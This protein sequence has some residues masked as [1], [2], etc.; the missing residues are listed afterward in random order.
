[1]RLEVRQ[2]QDLGERVRLVQRTRYLHSDDVVRLELP[3]PGLAQVDVLHLTCAVR[4]ASE[5]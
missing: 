5:S 2:A 3:D 4:L 1:M